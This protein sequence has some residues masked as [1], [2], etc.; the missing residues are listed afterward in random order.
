MFYLNLKR[1]PFVSAYYEKNLVYVTCSRQ[2]LINELNF[3]MV[4]FFYLLNLK[5]LLDQILI[6]NLR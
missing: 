5:I 6:L 2:K 1:L 3:T 4:E